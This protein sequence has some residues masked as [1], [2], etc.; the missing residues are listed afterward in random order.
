MKEIA[1]YFENIFTCEPDKLDPFTGET[2][3]ETLEGFTVLFGS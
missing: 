2:P 3:I 1:L